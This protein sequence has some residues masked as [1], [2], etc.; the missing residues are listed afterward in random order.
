LIIDERISRGVAL[1]LE[2]A[3]LVSREKALAP[4]IREIDRKM[5]AIFKKQGRLFVV[6]FPKL[7]YLFT[8][9]IDADNLARILD[10]IDAET[11]PQMKA[12]LRTNTQVAYGAGIEAGSEI[13][14]ALTFSL[15][16]PAAV[17]WLEEHAAEAV[18]KIDESTRSVISN[19]VTQGVEEGW[20]YNRTARAIRERYE[21]FAVGQPQHHIQSR[22]HLVALTESHTAYGEGHRAGIEPLLKVGLEVEKSWVNMGDDLVSDGCLENSDAGWIPYDEDFPSGDLAEPRFPGCRCNVQYRV[23]PAENA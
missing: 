21:E 8:E 15:K 19:L 7:S 9:N 3:R 1:L 18:T 11:S 4:V 23:K 16:H 13:S 12:V 22:A 6:E 14:T 10:R 20:S 17:K 2:A 5:S